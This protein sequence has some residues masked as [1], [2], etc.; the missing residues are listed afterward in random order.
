MELLPSELL[1]LELWNLIINSIKYTKIRG[2][3]NIFKK[4]ADNIER[5]RKTAIN[6]NMSLFQKHISTKPESVTFVREIKSEY[7][8][9]NGCIDELRFKRVDN[10]YSI[11][12]HFEC[13]KVC[14][15][16]PYFNDD[17]C[18]ETFRFF[19]RRDGLS[20]S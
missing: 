3:C 13:D 4:I 12:C 10:K 7:T 2:V 19:G 8:E 14:I 17:L 18:S 6:I 20:W 5:N 16:K 1:P 15:C 11:C 9:L